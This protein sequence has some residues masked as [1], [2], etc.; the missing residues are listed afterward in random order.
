MEHNWIQ[1]RWLV[2]KITFDSDKQAHVCYSLQGEAE[3]DGMFAT[4]H[5]VLLSNGLGY[6]F[7]QTSV[8]GSIHINNTTFLSSSSFQP[9]AHTKTA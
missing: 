3:T 7:T 4:V 5:S 6:T 8:L 9:L 1:I 2:C